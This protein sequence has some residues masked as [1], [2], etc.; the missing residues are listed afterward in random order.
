M[1]TD[2]SSSESK[3]F[4]ISTDELSRELFLPHFPT[5]SFSRSPPAVDK[6]SYFLFSDGDAEYHTYYI[7]LEPSLDFIFLLSISFAPFFIRKPF[8]LLQFL[9]FKLLL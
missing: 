1:G 5:S 7:D 8:F 9:A 6:P 3:L 2:P 4:T